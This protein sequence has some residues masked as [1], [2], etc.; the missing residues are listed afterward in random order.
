MGRYDPESEQAMI[1]DTKEL[2]VEHPSPEELAQVHAQWERE[3]RHAAWF[4]AHLAEIVAAHSGKH[5]CIA[6]QGPFAGGSP[7]EVSSRARAAHPEDDGYLLRY[8]PRERTLR[9]S[10]HQRQVEANA[11]RDRPTYPPG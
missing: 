7:E 2:V 1:E 10:A 6:G 9:I 3:D 4:E 5:I 11:R 8:I